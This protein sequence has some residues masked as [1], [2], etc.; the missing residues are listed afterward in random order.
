[1]LGRSGA[2]LVSMVAATPFNRLPTRTSGYFDP[3]CIQFLWICGSRLQPPHPTLYIS[4]WQIKAL[5]ML[6]PSVV[7]P[8]N[9]YF[10]ANSER[11]FVHCL[12]S[13][14]IGKYT[15]SA[16]GK[17]LGPR[18]GVF[19]NTSLLSTVYGYNIEKW[20]FR[21]RFIRE[22]GASSDIELIV[23]KTFKIDIEKRTR[24]NFNLWLI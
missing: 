17:S 6:A 15:P 23:I 12:E 14:C 24:D 2:A 9:Q 20:V 8:Q 16:L 1:M 3:E 11:M 22:N 10:P 5:L 4:Y 13:G 21:R 7:T 19:S 18:G